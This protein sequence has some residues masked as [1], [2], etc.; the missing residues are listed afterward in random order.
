MAQRLT[1]S[2]QR[3]I[4]LLRS[5]FD[6]AHSINGFKHTEKTGWWQSIHSASS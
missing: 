6:T 2:G 1:D 5:M 4:Q 3:D